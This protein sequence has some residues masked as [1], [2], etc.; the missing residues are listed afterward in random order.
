VLQFG[1]QTIAMRLVMDHLRV[2]SLQAEIAAIALDARIVREVVR[3]AS[4]AEIILSLAEIPRGGVEFGLV[5]PAETALR[6]DVE[7]ARPQVLGNVGVRNL[8]SV[9][10]WSPRE[11]SRCPPDSPS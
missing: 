9:D 4:D 7:D 6:D 1:E 11:C 8:D 5:G 3:M 2:G 10:R